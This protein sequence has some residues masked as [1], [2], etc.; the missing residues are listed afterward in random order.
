MKN[1]ILA[2]A[3]VA[4]AGLSAAAHAGTITYSWN[5]STDT[6]SVGDTVVLTLHASINTMGGLFNGLAVS[7]FNIGVGDAPGMGLLDNTAPGAGLKPSFLVG[8]QGTVVGNALIG[9]Q[10]AQFPQM[11][12]PGI[13]TA[14]EV[15]LY[16]IHYTILDG[17]P[18]EILFIA[19]IL[20]SKVYTNAF[21]NS[22]TYASISIPFALNVVPVPAP[23]A[24]ALLGVAGAVGLRRRRNVA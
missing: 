3:A 18:R 15:D 17:T 4:A 11:L 8:H 24:L 21:G 23:G 14:T 16:T 9:A 5:A 12:N 10:A 2:F 7:E 6:A 19:S 1:A 13:N 22:E 20:D